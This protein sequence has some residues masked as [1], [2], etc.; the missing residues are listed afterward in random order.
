M[1]LTNI[2]KGIKTTALAGV[3]GLSSFVSGCGEIIAGYMVSSAVREQGK[4]QQDKRDILTRNVFTATMYKGYQGGISPNNVDKEDFV[5]YEKSIFQEKERF[6]VG[7][8]VD[9]TPTPG[10]DVLFRI[11][12]EERGDTFEKRYVTDGKYVTMDVFTYKNGLW[13]GTYNVELFLNGEVISSTRFL[14]T[15]TSNN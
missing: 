14:V 3:L 8:V 11:K 12:D 4:K 1:S 15:P 2:V 7:F 5:N 9:G 10:K 13:K 6:D